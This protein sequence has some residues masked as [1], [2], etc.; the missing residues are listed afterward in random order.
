MI[1]AHTV[2]LS[3]L[4]FVELKHSPLA[5]GPAQIHYRRYGSG[6]PLIFL[7]GGWGYQIYPLSQQQVN[8][9]GVQVIIPDR[10]GYG[11]ST[12]PSIFNAEFHRL[13]MGETLAFMDAL[14]I[15]KAILWGHSDGA[16]I[17]V[18]MGLTAPQR[19]RGVILEALHYYRVKPHSHEFF[20]TMMRDQ[21]S[22]GPRVT[23]ILESDHGPGWRD[24]IRGDGEAWLEIANLESPHPDLYEGRLSEMKVPVALIHGE[25]DP[26]TEPDEIERVRREIPAAQAHIIAGAGHSP[27]SERGSEEEV[28]RRVRE[29][30]A[31]WTEANRDETGLP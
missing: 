19:C 30:F 27:H 7:H 11:H 13:A 16:V 2:L 25:A 24:A 8:I 10:S 20:T 14:G 15:G 28:A 31:G 17:S 26:R 6:Q 12:K 3:C 5:G 21:D 22:L 23:S 29:I 1:A 4:P 18:W 9:P